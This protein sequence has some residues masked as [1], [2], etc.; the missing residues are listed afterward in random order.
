[1]TD[2]FAWAVALGMGAVNY[3]LRI[4]PFAALAKARLPRPVLRWLSFVPVAVMAALVVGE[5]ARPGGEWVVPWLNPWLYA[6][7]GTAAAYR[8]SRSFLGATVIGI[9][10]FVGARWA[11]GAIG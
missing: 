9:A 7:L 1:M 3:A 5:V 8:L 11:L 4:T 2:Q 6:A 10:L